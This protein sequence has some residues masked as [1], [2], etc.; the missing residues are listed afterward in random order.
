MIEND[1]KVGRKLV[2]SNRDPHQLIG[3]TGLSFWLSNMLCFSDQGA[4]YT[5]FSAPSNSIFDTAKMKNNTNQSLK[6]LIIF[7]NTGLFKVILA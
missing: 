7:T 1:L 5:E 4:L 6:V 2:I 3:T